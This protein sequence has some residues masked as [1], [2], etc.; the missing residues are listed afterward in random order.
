M[1]NNS[2][3]SFCSS[4]NNNNSSNNIDNRNRLISTNLYHCSR[5]LACSPLGRLIQAT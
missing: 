3:F 5:K 2:C 4:S 1:H